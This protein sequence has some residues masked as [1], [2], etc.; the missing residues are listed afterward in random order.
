MDCIVHG[1]AKTQTQ[2]SDFHSLA[3]SL[4]IML[5]L[6]SRKLRCTQYSG[7]LYLVEE[8]ITVVPTMG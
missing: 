7:D 5:L 6:N 1:V 3:H 4:G 8:W 2:L